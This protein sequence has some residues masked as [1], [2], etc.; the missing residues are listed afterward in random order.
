MDKIYDIIHN[1]DP[2]KRADQC[3]IGLR[4]LVDLVKRLGARSYLEIGCAKL[5]TYSVFLDALQSPILSIGIDLKSYLEW[6]DFKVNHEN[7][8]FDKGSTN[9]E[10]LTKVK[11]IMKDRKIDVLFIDGNHNEEFVQADWDN[12]SPYVRQGGLI[13]FHDWDPPALLN[14]KRE[15]QGAAIVC[16]RLANKGYNIEH[17]PTT[18]IGTAYLYKP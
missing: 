16:N 15:G 3:E 13:I 17:V 9:S 8:L 1:L 6:K 4:Y 10:V 14:G 11:A 2:L 12:F 18:C 5:L 7:Y